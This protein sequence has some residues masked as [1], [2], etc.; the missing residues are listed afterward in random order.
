METF[1]AESSP[2]Y[3]GNLPNMANIIS[4][5]SY[6]TVWPVDSQIVKRQRLSQKMQAVNPETGYWQSEYCILENNDE[7]GQ[8]NKRDLGMAT[9]LFVARII[10]ND[11]TLCNARSWQWWTALTQFDL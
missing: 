8:G 5:H 1:F 10:H 9:A 6:F 2:L 3:I 4:A 7:V 11:L